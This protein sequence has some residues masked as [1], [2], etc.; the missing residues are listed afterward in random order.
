MDKI[1]KICKQ[2]KIHLIED[3]A[4]TLGAK[5]KHKYTGSFG[6]GC[7]SFFQ[8]KILLLPRAAC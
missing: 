5:F 2:K 1:V 7:F 8:Q 4:E 3:S 6:I